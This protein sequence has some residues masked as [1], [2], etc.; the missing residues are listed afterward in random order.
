MNA[1]P[2]R[3]TP[4]ATCVGA[5]SMAP[6]AS[7]GSNPRGSESGGRT[8]R[9]PV[10]CSFSMA[11][12]TA[13]TYVLMPVHTGTTP[14]FKGD[15]GVRLQ[16]RINPAERLR[17]ERSSLCPVRE[18]RGWASSDA[19]DPRIDHRED[20]RVEHPFRRA[21]VLGRL[22][23]LA[24]PLARP[25]MA[26]RALPR[27][28]PAL[29]QCCQAPVRRVVRR[30][31]A[32]GRPGAPPL[33][34]APSPGRGRAS[35][36]GAARAAAPR[37]VDEAL[38]EA[39]DRVRRAERRAA[40]LERALAAVERRAERAE[41]LLGDARVRA[42]RASERER[43]ARGAR[44]RVQVAERESSEQVDMLTADANAR[45]RAAY[46]QAQAGSPIRTR[47]A[48]PSVPPKCALPTQRR[49]L[50]RRSGLRGRRRRRLGGGERSGGEPPAARQCG[51]GGGACGRGSCGGGRAAL[52]RAGDAR[53]RRTAAADPRRD[54]AL[55]DAGPTGP[56]VMANALRT[57]HRARAAGDRRGLTDALGDVARPRSA[58]ATGLSLPPQDD[59]AP[60]IR[61]GP[62]GRHQ[63]RG[64]R[65][66]GPAGRPYPRTPCSS[67]PTSPAPGA[68][69]RSSC[70]RASMPSSTR[71]ASAASCSAS[72][73]PTPTSSRR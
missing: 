29:D 45:V 61:P 25:G 8:P 7:Q 60:A 3:C 10:P 11:S 6:L 37:S 63:F 56:A 66:V 69:R 21:P 42:R 41:D 47:P 67:S 14:W 12:T 57:L 34:S 68:T 50:T 52:A 72:G 46:D 15:A 53:L 33:R 54:A 26:H 30:R 38:L 48:G 20:P 71:C 65:P 64:A 16:A 70:S 59:G 39:S 17:A 58:G 55:R 13:P 24:G 23:P 1:L 22:G 18:H 28:D 2:R 4:G 36:R 35:G 27:W 51:D 49:V 73:P 43:R 62:T 32:R 31:R 5:S 19:L 40:E 9:E 44:D